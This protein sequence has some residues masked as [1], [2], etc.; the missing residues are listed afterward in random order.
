MRVSDFALALASVAAQPLRRRAADAS[1]ATAADMV[2]EREIT[3]VLLILR[4]DG[5]L[6]MAAAARVMDSRS[7]CRS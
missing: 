3:A 2:L 6:P 4:G 7:G 1:A 5:E